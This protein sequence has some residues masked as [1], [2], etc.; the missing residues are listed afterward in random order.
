M[1]TP[2]RTAL[3]RTRR[4]AARNLFS[5]LGVGIGEEPQ[6]NENDKQDEQSEGPD[7][8][9]TQF[10]GSG[11]EEERLKNSHRHK[12][13]DSHKEDGDWESIPKIDRQV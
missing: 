5:V 8:C 11:V 9:T 12:S 3:T 1:A 13:N 4:G 2:H 6:N 7:I 10:L